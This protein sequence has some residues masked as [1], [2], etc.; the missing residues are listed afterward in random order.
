[1]IFKST[2][3]TKSI[4]GV[5]SHPTEELCTFLTA[6]LLFCRWTRGTSG[7]RLAPLAWCCWVDQHWAESAACRWLRGW[8]TV[9]HC[10][11]FQDTRDKNVKGNFSFRS[12]LETKSF[13][14]ICF[15]RSNAVTLIKLLS[16]KRRRS[17]TSF[18]EVS[19][20]PT[21]C[22][23]LA[24]MCKDVF[25]ARRIKVWKWQSG[26]FAGYRG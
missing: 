16:E 22:S 17:W 1:M 23:S 18:T 12:L 20:F 10:C 6:T 13:V 8:F 3:D 15:V 7:R 11:A 25:A 2:S 14:Q 26:D 4:A 21:I 5:I 19:Q 24:L 9:A